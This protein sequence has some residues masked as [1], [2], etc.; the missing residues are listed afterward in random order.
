[1]EIMKLLSKRQWHISLTLLLFWMVSLAC[2]FQYN[3][4]SS[5]TSTPA[6]S[7][8]Q[9]LTGKT[10][11]SQP[12]VSTGT[13]QPA[14]GEMTAT[15]V[16]DL[17]QPDPLD[18]L[19]GMHSIKFDLITTRPDGT[20]RSLDGEIDSTGNM[21]LIFGYK[22][23]D[24]S[25]TPKGFDPKALPD[26]AEM[27]VI[28]GKAYQLDEQNPDWSTIPIDENYGQTLSQELHGMEGPALWL[29]ILPA[30]SIQPAGQENIGGFAADKYTVDGLVDGQKISGT[31]W[32]EPKTDALVQAE[33]HVPAALLSSPDKP[34]NGELKVNLQ[35]QKADVTP[36][37]LPSSPAGSGG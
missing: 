29:N 8:T 7:S 4:G 2:G 5:G 1:M 37:T 6:P 9:Q 18:H 32:E 22:G 24:L 15:A 35:A 20:I 26:S 33:L 11:I 12:S 10:G 34:M 31:L 14:G 21:H 30:G 19:L 27:Y 28:D 25:G 13:D 3:F 17:T 16:D 23:F 36:V